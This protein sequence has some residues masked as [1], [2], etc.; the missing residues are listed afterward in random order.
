[1][2]KTNHNLSKKFSEMQQRFQGL[3]YS[4]V[5]GICLDGVESWDLTQEVF[6]KAFNCTNFWN[7]GFNQK[8][9]LVTVARNEA[10]KYRRSLKS[11][12]N[13]LVRFCGLEDASE[14]R[15]LETR[16]IRDEDVARLRELL[17]KLDE[18]DR[19]IITLRFNAEMSYQQIADEMQIK[20]GTVMSRLAR[21]KERLGLEYEEEEK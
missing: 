15:E 16:L 5:Y 4:I 12:L 13:Y 9:W 11:R 19:Q 21:L 2:T 20:I 3:V 10:L 17:K 18:D 8:A 7:E 1:M 14:A 6:M